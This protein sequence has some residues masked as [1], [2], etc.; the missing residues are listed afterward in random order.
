MA[1]IYVRNGN[2]NLVPV[3]SGSN[4]GSSSGGNGNIDFSS[5]LTLTDKTTGNSYTLYIDN[6]KLTMVESEG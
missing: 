1:I 3:G 2:G 4:S 5:G 6:G